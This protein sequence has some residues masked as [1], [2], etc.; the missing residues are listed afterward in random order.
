MGFNSPLIRETQWVLIVP[1]NKADY[2]LGVSTWA[3]FVGRDPKVPMKLKVQG[4]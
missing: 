1:K 4:V 2:F 3:F